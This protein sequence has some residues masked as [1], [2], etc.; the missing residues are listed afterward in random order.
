MDLWWATNMTHRSGM[1]EGRVVD[2]N[3]FLTNHWNCCLNIYRVKPPRNGFIF[4]DTL[5]FVSCDVEVCWLAGTEI[6]IPERKRTPHPTLELMDAVITFWHRW[7]VFH[8]RRYLHLQQIKNS[9][10][11]NSISVGPDFR[12]QALYVAATGYAHTLEPEVTSQAA[13]CL[14]LRHT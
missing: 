11:I 4:R 10:Y 1:S 5:I 2:S 6:H 8:C 14:A 9:G 7:I 13:S 3:R 12:H